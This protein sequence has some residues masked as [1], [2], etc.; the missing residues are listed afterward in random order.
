MNKNNNNILCI[1]NR[2]KR[3][4]WLDAVKGVCIL[5]ILVSH[6]CNIPF[7]GYYLFAGY[8]QVFFIASG[9]TFKPFSKKIL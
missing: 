6:Y 2:N 1:D 9:Y 4:E 3:I 8:V 5:L 7:I